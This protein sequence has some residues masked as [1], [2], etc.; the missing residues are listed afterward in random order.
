MKL[1]E[2]DVRAAYFRHNP[3]VDRFMRDVRDARLEREYEG[4]KVEVDI[5]IAANI[6][7]TGAEQT[8][9]YLANSDAIDRLWA[10]MDKNMDE[11]FP[12]TAKAKKGNR[13]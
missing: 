5:L 6:T 4:M 7:L 1:D 9:K 10:R 2:R 12:E 11:R 3:N 8:R 13:P